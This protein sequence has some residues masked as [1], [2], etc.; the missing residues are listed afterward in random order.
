MGVIFWDFD[1]TIASRNGRWAGALLDALRRHQPDTGLARE[2]LAP[3]LAEGFPWH[4]PERAHPEL[5]LPGAWW[6]AAERNFLRVYGAAGVERDLAIRAAPE[7][8]D[9]YLAADGWVVFD[10]VLP[11]LRS[12]SAAGWRHSVISNHV[13]ELSDLMRRLGLADFFLDV[14]SS[15]NAGYEKPNPEIFRIAL[16]R[17][18]YPKD[19]WMVGD[20][21]KGD[22]LAAEAAGIPSILVRKRDERARQSFEDLRQMAEWL[23]TNGGGGIPSPFGERLG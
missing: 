12:L 21:L 1:R 23:V 10:D 6:Q 16:E 18:G 11:A 20:N 4:A 19:A 2:D 22:V 14:V 17:A 7:V 15:A 13:P 8:R 3:L 9:V 5:S